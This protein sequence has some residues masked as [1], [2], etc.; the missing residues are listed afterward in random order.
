MLKYNLIKL[1][2][3]TWLSI[4]EGWIYIQL[5]LTPENEV[6]AI[7]YLELKLIELEIELELLT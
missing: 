5:L 4:K 7:N 3:I 6:G 2:K 1:L